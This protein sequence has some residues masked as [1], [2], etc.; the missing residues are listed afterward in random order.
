M[1]IE[2]ESFPNVIGV[3]N[4]NNFAVFPLLNDKKVIKMFL[5]VDF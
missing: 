2:N 4:Y 5:S 1:S 3:R